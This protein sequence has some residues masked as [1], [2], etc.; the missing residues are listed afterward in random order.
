MRTDGNWTVQDIPRSADGPVAGR[1]RLNSGPTSTSAT[2]STAPPTSSK[3]EPRTA[4]GGGDESNTDE[5][6]PAGP[7]PAPEDLVVAT[8]DGAGS[9]R[10]KLDVDAPRGP[11]SVSGYQY[12]QR[13]VQEAPWAG[14]SNIADLDLVVES[15]TM[16]SYT[17]TGPHQ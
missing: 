8:E 16:R 5:A 10:V 17:V 13:F 12:Q 11:G 3:Y 4:N 15:A 2:S 6:T 14:W 1:R 9:R 7:L